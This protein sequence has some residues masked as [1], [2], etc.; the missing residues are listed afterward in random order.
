MCKWSRDR[1]IKHFIFTAHAQ[2][3]GACYKVEVSAYLSKVFDYKEM[4]IDVGWGI[5]ICKMSQTNQFICLNRFDVSL[6]FFR[7]GSSQSVFV[8]CITISIF[9]TLYL[10]FQEYVKSLL[11]INFPC[12]S[13]RVCFLFHMEWQR[14]Y[15]TNM[16][17]AF[18][19]CIHRVQLLFCDMS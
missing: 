2:K 11:W 19:S 12:L 5:T 13:D 8:Y 4:G 17:L 1:I 18:S 16:S 10:I 14:W 7:P 15:M 6:C 3:L 9:L